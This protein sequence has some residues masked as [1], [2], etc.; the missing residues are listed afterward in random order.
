VLEGST[1]M[2]QPKKI[3]EQG[4]HEPIWKHRSHINRNSAWFF[5]L[6]TCAWKQFPRR[7]EQ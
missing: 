5:V 3:A 1:A 7:G 4:L 6:S 2:C